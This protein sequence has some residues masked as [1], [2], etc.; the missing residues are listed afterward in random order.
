M[1]KWALRVI[2]A[3]ALIFALS[4]AVWVVR[5]RAEAKEAFQFNR[6]SSGY[7]AMFNPRTGELYMRDRDSNTWP[8]IWKPVAVMPPEDDAKK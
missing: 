6:S 7:T 8:D 2:A 1:D 4:F 5:P 3:A